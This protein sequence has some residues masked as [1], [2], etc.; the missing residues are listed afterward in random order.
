MSSIWKLID[1]TFP[2]DRNIALKEIEKKSKL[3]DLELEIQI[4][5]HMKTLSDL[6]GCWCAWYSREGDCRKHQKGS[7]RAAL[8]EIQKICMLRSA[9]I[10]RKVLVMNKMI[11]LS[12]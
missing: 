9:R 5:W 7:E 2:S 8:R 12:D 10:V 11:D 6:C 3:K 4:M 1:M